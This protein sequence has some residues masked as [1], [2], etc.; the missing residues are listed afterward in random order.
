[1]AKIKK[2]ETKEKIEVTENGIFFVKLPKSKI[3]LELKFLTGKDERYL[4]DFIGKVA[5]EDGP[6]VTDLYSRFIVSVN[7]NEDEEHIKDFIGSMLAFDSKFLRE[8]YRESSPNINVNQIFE[9]KHPIC[10]AK[11]SVQIPITIQFFWPN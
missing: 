2:I 1:M 4:Q 7:G 5:G 9:C 8:K 10:G 6:T 11:T 3:T